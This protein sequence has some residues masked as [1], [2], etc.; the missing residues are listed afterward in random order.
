MV[1]GGPK[2]FVLAFSQGASIPV[3]IPVLRGQS[4]TP[5]IEEV[6]DTFYLGG[7]SLKDTNPLTPKRTP[8]EKD[9]HVLFFA[10]L[11]GP[12][13]LNKECVRRIVVS[14]VSF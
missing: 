9:W 5:P 13:G 3:S 12:T 2:W 7:Y 6:R 1:V 10:F 14:S 8:G 4:E 11:E